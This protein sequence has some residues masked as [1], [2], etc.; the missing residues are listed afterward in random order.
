VKASKAFWDT[1]IKPIT[2]YFTHAV[3]CAAALT[4]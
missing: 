2:A 3:N 4:D 1:M